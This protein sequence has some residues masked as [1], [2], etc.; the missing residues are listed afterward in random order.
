MVTRRLPASLSS[1]GG[2]HVGGPCVRARRRVGA[3][4]GVL[5]LSAALLPTALGGPAQA[6][7]V[8]SAQFGP[9]RHTFSAWW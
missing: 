8:R 6:A 9:G 3:V 4:A 5:G 2:E 7:D 1:A